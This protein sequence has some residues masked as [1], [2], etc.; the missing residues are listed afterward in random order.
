MYSV[1]EKVKET[2]DG[3][4]IR[5]TVDDD[6]NEINVS[7]SL[8]NGSDVTFHLFFKNDDS[9]FELRCFNIVVLHDKSN[10]EALYEAVN[11]LNSEYRYIKFVIDEKDRVDAEFDMSDMADIGCTGEVVCEM[12]FR[13][14]NILE[15]EIPYLMKAAWTGQWERIDEEETDG[16]EDDEEDDD[17]MISIDDL[18]NGDEE[19]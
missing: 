3:Y 11:A 1:V 15:D 2:L 5:Y 12:L 13:T 8:K 17:G 6:D 16:E 18:L 10:R 7:Y 9:G 14:C 4:G 19:E